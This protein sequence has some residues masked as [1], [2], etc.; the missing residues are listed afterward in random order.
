MKPLA[1]IAFLAVWSAVMGSF[2]WFSWYVAPAPLREWAEEEGCRIVKRRNTWIFGW[3]TFAQGN[4][5]VVYRVVVLDKAGH[6][7]SGLARVGTPYWWC[8][9][10][11]RCPV[12]IR[13]DSAQL[14]R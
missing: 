10:P 12:E 6:T 2:C 11:S 1:L 13:W 8:L 7:H 3:I 9:S 4:C 14:K 5:Q